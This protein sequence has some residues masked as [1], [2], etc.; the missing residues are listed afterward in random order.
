MRSTGVYLGVGG[1]L[2]AP[3]DAQAGRVSVSSEQTKRQYWK[4]PALARTEG[5]VR[6]LTKCLL[7]APHCTASARART[8]TLRK[9]MREGRL[10]T[11]QWLGQRSWPG[12]QR[13]G[14]AL[15]GLAVF[16]GGAGNL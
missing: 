4:R 3:T 9:E 13:L 15:S 16:R 12:P 1:S 5:I 10:S 11:C 6:E 7:F 2:A 8:C 14:N